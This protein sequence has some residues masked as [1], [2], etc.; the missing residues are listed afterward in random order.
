MQWTLRGPHLLYRPGQRSIMTWTRC[1]VDGTP[2]SEIMPP[3]PRLLEPLSGP[4]YCRFSP[5]ARADFRWTDRAGIRNVAALILVVGSF[6]VPIMLIQWA[7]LFLTYFPIARP[8]QRFF[9]PSVGLILRWAQC[10][11][12]S[13][14]RRGCQPSPREGQ[15]NI[16]THGPASCSAGM[17]LPQTSQV[18]KARP[19]PGIEGV[20]KWRRPWPL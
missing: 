1:S 18:S 2:G 16:I 13:R 8:I 3:D 4:S 11:D 6:A 17:T 9:A 5:D 19:R 14:G 10:N 20:P 12:V 7:I 15:S